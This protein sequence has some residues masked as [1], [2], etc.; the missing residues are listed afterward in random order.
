MVHEMESTVRKIKQ[1]LKEAKDRKKSY[2]DLKRIHLEFQVAHHIYLKVKSQ[3]GSLNIGNCAKLEP[4]FCGLF[5]IL[6]RIGLV[7]YQLALLPNLKIHNVFYV[8]LLNNYV[9]DPT[10]MID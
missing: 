5:Y 6:A 2:V 10:H 4:R 8:S 3:K 9:H 1:N 7:A